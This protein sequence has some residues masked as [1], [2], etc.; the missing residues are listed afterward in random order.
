MP[1][2]GE[3]ELCWAE[4]SSSWRFEALQ[5]PSCITLLSEPAGL[6]QGTGSIFPTAQQE[7][8]FLV[9]GVRQK[10]REGRVLLPLQPPGKKFLV[11]LLQL[12]DTRNACKPTLK[13]SLPEVILKSLTCLP[14]TYSLTYLFI[15]KDRIIIKFKV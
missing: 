5:F 10:D 14:I 12:K 7:C 6:T 4:G 1:S 8:K 3:H 13:K 9:P 11:S 2:E 15:I